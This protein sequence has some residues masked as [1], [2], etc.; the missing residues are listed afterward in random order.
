M[1]DIFDSVQDSERFCRDVQSGFLTITH[2]V[3][4]SFLYPETGYDID[5]QGKGLLQ[6]P[7]LVSVSRSFIYT[8]TANLSIVLSAYI[9]HTTQT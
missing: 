9:R 5:A 7:L 6:S 1:R 2:H 3:W 4:P 8:H